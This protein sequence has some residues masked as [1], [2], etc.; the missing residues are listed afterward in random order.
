MHRFH[1]GTPDE[2]ARDGLTLKDLLRPYDVDFIRAAYLHL[3]GRP[4][5]AAELD[6]WLSQVRGGSQSK[7]DVLVAI[8]YSL[9]GRGRGT[10]VPG[11]AM[12]RAFRT[13]LRL[14]VIGYALRCVWQLVTLS[15]LARRV[16]TIE[17]NFMGHAKVEAQ[18]L[19]RSI[20]RL[21]AAIESGQAR[22]D[23]IETRVEGD[24]AATG[25]H[26]ARLVQ[27]LTEAREEQA[28]LADE[29]RRIDEEKVDRQAA[30][31]LSGRLTAVAGAVTMLDDVIRL[32]GL[33]PLAGKDGI[34][35]SKSLDD[36]YGR[37]E[38][39]FRGPPEQIRER[40]SFYL[41]ILRA[42]AETMPEGATPRFADLGCGRGEMIQLLRENGLQAYGVDIS[43]TMLARCRELG[44]AVERTDA[45]KHLESLEPNSLAGLTS[46][47]M[48]EHMP[49]RMLVRL[50]NE[51]LRVL[52]PGGV[53]IFETPNPENLIVGACNF[54][55]DP[56]HVRQ[57]P[58]EPTRFI[59]ESSGFERVAIERLHPGTTP[60]QVDEVTELFPK[61]IEP[62][63]VRD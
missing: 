46:I 42:V 51:A 7:M 25:A 32:W 59:L 12:R 19:D 34:N 8:R 3:L 40:L 4:P 60:N 47:H 15:E 41:P 37:F 63:V 57:L 31:E 5:E 54:Y 50:F 22:I 13:P 56:T 55:Y 38:D 11:L 61:W 43:D 39:H 9:E 23:T 58:P 1:F 62:R 27:Q 44:L 30:D 48:I 52:R 35:E 28:R 24:A 29:L 33:L 21:E 18:H 36:Y 53:A 6:Q 16:N 26:N 14:P 49:F 17:N 20:E 2:D 10:H 45:I